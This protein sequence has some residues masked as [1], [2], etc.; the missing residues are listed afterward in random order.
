MQNKIISEQHQLFITVEEAI[1][2][3][4]K[5]KCLVSLA[6]KINKKAFVCFF[7][8][9]TNKSSPAFIIL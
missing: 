7:E 3:V 5:A 4:F 1:K 2:I 6:C 9:E 8:N